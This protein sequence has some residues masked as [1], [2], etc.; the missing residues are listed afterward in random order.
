MIHLVHE[1]KYCMVYHKGQALGHC[2]LNIF[3]C[4]LSYF[5]EATYIANY[6]DDTTPYSAQEFVR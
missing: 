2:Y 4:D 5:L 3:L 1:R 6:A